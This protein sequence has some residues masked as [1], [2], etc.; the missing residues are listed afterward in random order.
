[1]T[2]ETDEDQVH[3]CK[4]NRPVWPGWALPA[5]ARDHGRP[6]L[7]GWTFPDDWDC[8]PVNFPY[9][10]DAHDFATPSDTIHS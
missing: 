6:R 7:Q 4:I 3:R 8:V 9:R 5:P 1:M 10:D 2:K